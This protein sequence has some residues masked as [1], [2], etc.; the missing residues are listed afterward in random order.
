MANV[1]SISEAVRRAP[2]DGEMTD[3]PPG[4]AESLQALNQSENNG[5]KNKEGKI[6]IDPSRDALLPE[7]SRKTLDSQYLLPGETYQ[8]CFA[9]AAVTGSDDIEHAR[10]LYEIF[11][12]LKALPATPGLKTGA[13]RAN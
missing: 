4:L 5:H 1:Q 8:E 10:R 7:C 13:C 2:H 12:T 3:L 9:R 6:E 11:S